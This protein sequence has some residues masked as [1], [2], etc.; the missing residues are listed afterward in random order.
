V[1]KNSKIILVAVVAAVLLGVL[2][3]SVSKVWDRE[4]K[5]EVTLSHYDDEPF[6]RNI[7][8]DV[9]SKSLKNGYA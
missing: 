4:S 3:Y 5:R 7:F 6:G 8:D 1:K 9:M 2:V